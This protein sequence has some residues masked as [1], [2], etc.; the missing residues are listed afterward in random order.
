MRNKSTVE[1]FRDYEWVV[2]GL[3]RVSVGV[4]RLVV[5]VACLGNGRAILEQSI[6]GVK[7][8]RIDSVE[9]LDLPAI[10]YNNSSPL[11]I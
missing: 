8:R 4:I 7:L 6:G 10:S 11:L 3:V 2:S 5:S 1:W 9:M